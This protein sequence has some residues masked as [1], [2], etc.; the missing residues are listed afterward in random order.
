MSRAGQALHNIIKEAWSRRRTLG[1]ETRDG[2][3]VSDETRKKLSASRN[4]DKAKAQLRE[5]AQ[6]SAENRRGKPL[7]RE[8]ILKCSTTRLSEEVVSQIRAERA[9]DKTH[10]NELAEKYGITVSTVYGVLNNSSWK[11]TK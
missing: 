8:R 3:V 11:K 7:D 2:K 1:V 10:V 6:N 9:K 4:N 5:A